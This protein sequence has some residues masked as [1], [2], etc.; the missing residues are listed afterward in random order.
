MILD[1]YQVDAFAN[2]MFTGNPAAVCLLDEWLPDETMQQIAMENN[3]SETAFFV[4]QGSGFALRWFT[5]KAEVA[6]CGHATLATAHVLFSHLNY[7]KEEVS[8]FTQSG[9]LLVVEK[10][11]SLYGMNF[12]GKSLERE[13][14]PLDLYH[15]L[16][17]EIADEVYKADD[18]MWVMDKEEKV[19][20]M[21][22]NFNLLA[23]VDTRG[24]IVTAPGNEV[25]FVSR[26]FAPAVGINEDP[27]TG[28]AHTMLTPYWSQRLG[29]DELTARQISS[30]GGELQC[31]LMDDGRVEIAGKACTYMKGKI[32]LEDRL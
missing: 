6:L 15:A 1:L 19:R 25:D 10:G 30:R 29:K 4:S 3:L 7:E 2:H 17:G 12:P 9:E 22:P 18:F 31:I 20:N 8:F 5:P 23:E 24:I 27:V 26:F 32:K 28:S 16:G 14:P 13:A 11:E 21:S